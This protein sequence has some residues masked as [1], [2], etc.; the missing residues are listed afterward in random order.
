M[1]R[2]KE[3]ATTLKTT[4]SLH[5]N[6]RFL[7]QI[8]MRKSCQHSATK[9]DEII[10]STVGVTEDLRDIE[11]S[12]NDHGMHTIVLFVPNLILIINPQYRTSVLH[13]F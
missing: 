3:R 5:I 2:C 11:N 7:K 8:T 4:S 10:V 12:E 1:I 9:E 13:P 6:T